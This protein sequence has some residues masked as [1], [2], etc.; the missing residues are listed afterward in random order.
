M[1]SLVEVLFSDLSSALYPKVSAMM[2]DFKFILDQELGKIMC[3]KITMPGSP[4][5]EI[6][7]MEGLHWEMDYSKVTG[8]N[9]S[10]LVRMEKHFKMIPE[11]YPKKVVFVKI[12]LPGCEPGYPE[13]WTIGRSYMPQ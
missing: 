6:S 12:T 3:L 5:F 10:C 8:S 7:Y 1:V 4:P 2:E 11:L 9:Y 13:R